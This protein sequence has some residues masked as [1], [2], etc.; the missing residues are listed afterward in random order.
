MNSNK[1]SLIIFLTLICLSFLS[2]ATIT[3]INSPGVWPVGGSVIANPQ[4]SNDTIVTITANNVIF[5]LKNYGL[6]QIST[7]TMTELIGIFVAPNLSNITI[8]NGT[9]ENVSGVGIYVSDGCSQVYLEN[10]LLSSCN[11]GG[12]LLAGNTTGTGINEVTIKNCLIND[13]IPTDSNNAYGLRLIATSNIIIEN[14]IINNS[15]TILSTTGYGISLESCSNGEIDHCKSYNNGGTLFGAGI[16]ISNSNGCSLFNCNAG[17]NLVT[18]LSQTGTACGFYITLSNLLLF[19]NCLGN[20]NINN[21][22]NAMGFYSLNNSNIFFEN[23]IAGAN[24]GGVL[25]A[26]LYSNTDNILGILYNTFNINTALAAG[27]NA[28]G[29]LLN[30]TQKSTI[31][32]NTIS[33]NTGTQGY[34]LVDTT[35]DTNNLIINNVSFNN[36][37]TGYVVNFTTGSFPVLF[38]SNNNFS[39]LANGSLYYNVAII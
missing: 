35:L 38:A 20:H 24:I 4:S 6:S 12:I 27:G 25:S 30:G 16:A 15:Q 28:Y 17:N 19:S 23:C 21:T 29:I 34:G 37:T 1:T 18:S 11:E 31:N 10:L 13:I 7:N 33:N 5:D 22:G 9:I 2:N 8:K 14:C 39:G 36:T 3:V 26:G 32:N